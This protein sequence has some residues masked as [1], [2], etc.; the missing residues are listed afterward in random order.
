MDDRRALHI[1]RSGAGGTSAITGVHQQINGEISYFSSLVFSADIRLHYQSLS[2]GGYLSSEYPLIIRLHYRDVNGDEF[3]A[4]HG[5]Y[6]Q[7]DTH[8]P[9]RNG[10]PVPRDQWVPYQTSNLLQSP[11]IAKPFQLLYIEIYAS[12]CDYESYISNVRLTV[13]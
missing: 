10:E 7:N 2:G 11:G 4:V 9:T 1:V 8:N 12:G 3:D 5:F 13:E 6:Y